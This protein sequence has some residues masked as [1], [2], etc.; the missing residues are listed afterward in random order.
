MPL[1]SCYAMLWVRMVFLTTWGETE[2]RALTQHLGIE[3]LV[4]QSHGVQTCELTSC[5]LQKD[6]PGLS[7]QLWYS[8]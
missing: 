5:S 7:A 3:T 1:A 8:A 4:R 6:V 2:C